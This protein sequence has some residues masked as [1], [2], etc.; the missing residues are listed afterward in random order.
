MYLTPLPHIDLVGDVTDTDCSAQN[1]SI[2]SR[3]CFEDFQT[4]NVCVWV[5]FLL[6]PHSIPFRD[7]SLKSMHGT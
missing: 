4:S 1:G 3:S 6:S 5:L 7:D 2:R